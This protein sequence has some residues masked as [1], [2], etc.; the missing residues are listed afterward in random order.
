MPHAPSRL[1][2]VAID[3]YGT[4]GRDLN[5]SAFLKLLEASRRLLRGAPPRP[6]QGRP[7]ARVGKKELSD[8]LAHGEPRAAAV[9]LAAVEEFARQLAGVI[10]RLLRRAAWRGTQRIIL[11]GGMRAGRVGELIAA[12]AV[13]LLH[14]ARH[15]VQ[16]VPIHHDPD[17]A[18]VV[19]AVHL[20]PRRVLRGHDGL[21]AVD[22]GGTNLRVGV[23]EVRRRRGLPDGRVA[24]LDIWRHASSPANLGRD[25]LVHRLCRML[26]GS[27]RWAKRHD[28]DLAP[29]VGV[30]C[31]GVI[32]P[33]GRIERGGHNL[34]GN[35]TSPRFNL[36]RCIVEAIP[37]IRGAAPTVVMHNDAVV[38]GLSELPFTRDVARWAVLTIGTGLGNARY[39][40]RRRRA[41]P[42]DPRPGGVR[43]AR[44]RRRRRG[45]RSR[46]RRA[47]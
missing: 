7:A 2:L 24:R 36:P 3:A 10:A 40:N 18:G 19:G 33:D 12:R 27:I 14:A 34:P 23:V 5:K 9:V 20:V 22:L 45:R 4:R 28:F 15:E 38:Q 42:A 44:R 29:V 8:I 32:A 46:A 26:R 1:E 13:L 6:F 30:A 39:S 35:W 25:Q 16:L 21:L 47:P 37:T 43:R 17:E 41:R 31:P 11:G